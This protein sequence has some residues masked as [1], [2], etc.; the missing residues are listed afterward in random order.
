MDILGETIPKNSN[1]QAVLLHQSF[2]FASIFWK[3]KIDLDKKKKISEIL[4]L[5]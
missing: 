1:L 5:S 2:F 3:K 4:T